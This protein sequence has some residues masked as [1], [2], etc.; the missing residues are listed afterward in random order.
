MVRKRKNE[1]KKK[2]EAAVVLVLGVCNLFLVGD[3]SVDLQTKVL[4]LY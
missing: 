4:I 3:C 2:K 1:K